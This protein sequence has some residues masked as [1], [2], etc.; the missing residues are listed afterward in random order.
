MFPW[1]LTVQCKCRSSLLNAI[2]WEWPSCLRAMEAE[3][4]L[5]LGLQLDCR[6]SRLTV[7]SSIKVFN[8]A[9]TGHT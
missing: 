5:M 2:T 9:M 7:F 4:L 3:V 6:S 1:F 8:L